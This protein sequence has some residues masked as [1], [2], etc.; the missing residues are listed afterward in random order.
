MDNRSNRFIVT[1]MDVYSRYLIAIPVRNHKA[2]TVSRCLYE[3]VVSYF[4]TP[5]SILS[6]RGTEFTSVIWE[7]LTQMLGA[8]IKLTAP[9]YPQ[10]NA[11]IE[12][13][14]RTLNNMLR[15]M[16]LEK[17]KENGAPCCPLSCY[18]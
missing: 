4:G 12:R 6:D 16:L 8:K 3:S 13:S 10:G 9:Y 2:S 15:T 7:S 18:I 1:I 14:H 11:V 5:R 17:N